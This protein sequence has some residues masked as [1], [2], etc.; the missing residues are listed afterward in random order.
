MKYEYKI[1]PMNSPLSH[2]NILYNMGQDGWEFICFNIYL[3][4]K[5][6]YF[7]KEIEEKKPDYFRADSPSGH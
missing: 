4:E 6:G 7:K 5:F 1:I 2:D 3:S